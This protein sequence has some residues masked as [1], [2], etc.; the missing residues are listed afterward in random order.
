MQEHK[1][2]ISNKMSLALCE[3]EL[4]A[5]SKDTKKKTNYGS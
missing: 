2:S 4:E 3:Y 1:L 5:S